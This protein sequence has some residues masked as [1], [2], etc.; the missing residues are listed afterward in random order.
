MNM[1]KVE[2]ARIIAVKMEELLTE[3]QMKDWERKKKALEK[4]FSEQPEVKKMFKQYCANKAALKTMREK[5]DAYVEALSKRLPP[6]AEL[7]FY[8]GRD[9]STPTLD[10]NLMTT[11]RGYRDAGQPP[12]PIQIAHSEV[13]TVLTK[14]RNS[15]NPRIRKAVEEGLHL[16]LE[17]DMK[18]MQKFLNL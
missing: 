11:H 6:D 17:D 10:V 18:R 3:E 2:R 1:D 14:H 16:M 5:I 4:W 8:D 15:D 9:N 12:G 13:V 7:R